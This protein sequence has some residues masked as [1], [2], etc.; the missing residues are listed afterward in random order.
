MQ[1]LTGVIQILTLYD[2]S[3]ILNNIP[4]RVYYELYECDRELY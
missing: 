1:S 4:E 2:C 3:V